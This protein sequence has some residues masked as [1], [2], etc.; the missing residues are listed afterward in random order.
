MHRETYDHLVRGERSR[1]AVAYSC[2]GL[3]GDQRSQADKKYDIAAVKAIMSKCLA[4]AAALASEPKPQGQDDETLIRHMMVKSD[5][6]R[7]CSL[8]ADPEER[9]RILPEETSPPKLLEVL[10]TRDGKLV[11]DDMRTVLREN[12]LLGH[13]LL[14]DGHLSVDTVPDL[15]ELL[16]LL[17]DCMHLKNRLYD[18]HAHF[19]PSSYAGQDS[20]YPSVLELGRVTIQGVWEELV[21]DFA[22]HS[23]RSPE[24]LQAELERMEAMVVQMRQLLDAALEN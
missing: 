13:S 11:G 15:D 20:N 4:K 8:S 17:W 24:H 21:D 14:Q 10:G 12:R 3:P 6:G 1:L 22:Q 23:Q 2:D 16:S 19:V 18:V 9:Q 7:I 5:L